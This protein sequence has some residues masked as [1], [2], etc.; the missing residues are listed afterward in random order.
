M[1]RLAL[2][3]AHVESKTG[4]YS[5]HTCHVGAV[6]FRSQSADPFHCGVLR[7]PS[8]CQFSL[9]FFWWG[10]RTFEMPVA[11]ATH[12]GGRRAYVR[13]GE[14]AN[15]HVSTIDQILGHI[16]G[17]NTARMGV[18]CQSIRSSELRSQMRSILPTF[19]LSALDQI[20]VDVINQE[21]PLLCT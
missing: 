18:G 4:S 3:R 12:T 1:L 16:L 20:W 17:S 13:I 10:L 15:I 19:I 9:I 11:C 8:R 21:S 5:C 6:G 14:S 2:L 7:K